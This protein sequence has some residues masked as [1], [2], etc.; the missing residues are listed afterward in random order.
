MKILILVGVQC[1]GKS[2]FAIDYCAKNSN[3]Y[4]VS[5]DEIRF[6]NGVEMFDNKGEEMVTRIVDAQ[7][8]VILE[9]KGNVILDATHCKWKYIQQIIDKFNHLADIEFKIF[10]VPLE[11]L[12]VRNTVRPRTLKQDIILKFYKEFQSLDKSLLISYPQRP[13]S[14][15]IEYTHEEGKKTC[16]ICDIDS[17]IAFS[18]HRS[19]Y[20]QQMRKSCKINVKKG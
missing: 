12:M 6:Q 15:Y 3:W 19:M 2:T 11:T 13:K 14:N 16:V 9:N 7:T 4:R 10:D 17:T 8:K 20:I 1:S 18:E 5:R